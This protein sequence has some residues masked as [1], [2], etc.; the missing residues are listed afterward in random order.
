MKNIKTLAKLGMLAAIG[1]VLVFFRFSIIPG[2]PYLEYDA[3]DIP[4]LIGGFLYGPVAGLCLTIVVS[5]LQFLLVSTASGPWG[6]V[7][8][9]IATGGLVVSASAIYHLQKS[10]KSALV[11][12]LHG[13]VIM[14]LTMMIAN[15]YITPLYSGMPQMA[16]VD[17]LIPAILPFNVIKSVVN[18]GI[19]FVLYKRVSRFFRGD[20]QNS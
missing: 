15:L 17:I 1:V 4:I 9:V 12:L 14:V 3:A 8:H 20:I 11:G 10:R 6:F 13:C 7:M 5:L 16:V 2:H 18:A 19:T